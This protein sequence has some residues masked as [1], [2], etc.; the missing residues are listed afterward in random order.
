MIEPDSKL[1]IHKQCD[2]ISLTKSSYYYK[3]KVSCIIKYDQVKIKL[4]E[5]W[6]LYPFMGARRLKVRLEKEGFS[7]S[8]SK[9]RKLMIELSIQAIGPKV[10]LSI[11]NKEHKIFPYL[12]RGVRPTKNNQIW[13]TDITYIKLGKSNVYLAAVI[14]WHSRFVLSW[15]LSN[16]MDTSLC[17]EPL[18]NSFRHG[19]PKIFNTDQGSQYTS[20]DHTKILLDRGIKVSMDGKGRALDNI[21]IERF[22]RSIKYEDILIKDYTTMEE[23]EKGINNYINF[24][25]YEREHQSLDYKTP[26]EIY[27]K[28]KKE[29]KLAKSA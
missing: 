24:Y 13:S 6:N 2:L 7:I 1:S 9:I 4:L 23:L 15:K 12:L 10:K 29:F 26:A 25:N 14:D 8:R 27:F 21:F 16:T 22:W 17:T 3:P 20:Y 19:K 11:P 18:V 5:I 28:Q